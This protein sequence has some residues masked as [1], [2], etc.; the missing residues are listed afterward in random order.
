MTA[1]EQIKAARRTTLIDE[2]GGPVTLE[3]LPPL[4]SGEMDALQQQVGQSLP[5]EL[6]SLLAFC[7]GIDG[8]FLEGIDFTGTGM[9]FEPQEVFP[10][11]LPIASDGYGNHWVLDLTPQSIRRTQMCALSHPVCRCTFRLW[12]CAMFFPAWG[13]HGEDTARGQSCGEMAL[14][15]FLDTRSLPA[16][17]FL[18]N[19]LVDRR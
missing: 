14:K 3:L 11:G 2:D 4:T 9:S 12:I 8:A 16:K 19:G 13:S 1:I 10:S 17:A 7:S 5:E 18:R 15:G 6:R